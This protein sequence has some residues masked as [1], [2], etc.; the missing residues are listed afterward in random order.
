LT[1]LVRPSKSG[2]ALKPLPNPNYEKCPTLLITVE[3]G[4]KGKFKKLNG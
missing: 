4:T 2:N 3:E 1:A